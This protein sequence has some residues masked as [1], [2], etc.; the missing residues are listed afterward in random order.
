MSKRYM[1]GFAT[2]CAMVGGT[3][4]AAQ[5]EESPPVSPTPSLTAQPFAAVKAA[6]KGREVPAQVPDRYI[7][8]AKPRVIGADPNTGQEYAVSSG[9]AGHCLIAV[10]TPTQSGFET[11]GPDL[12]RDNTVV[13][14]VGQGRVRTIVLQAQAATEA[15]TLMKSTTAQQTKVAPGLWVAESTGTL[16]G[17]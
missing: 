1:I 2:C 5:S 13:V 10:R 9:T 3:A 17:N 16:P 6:A 4:M 8:L 12:D 11:C 14:A 15:P 7:D